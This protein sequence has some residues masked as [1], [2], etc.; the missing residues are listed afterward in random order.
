MEQHQ[1]KC[2]REMVLVMLIS[3]GFVI[4][5][6]WHI[7]DPRLQ[8]LAM[9][10]LSTA[11]FLIAS[12]KV[13]RIANEQLKKTNETMAD[14]K[15]E[16]REN[17]DEMQDAVH[18]AECASAAKS[19]FLNHMSHDIRT[20]MNAIIGY[21]SLLEE[22]YQDAER[23]Q[24]YANKIT[25]SSKILLGLID[26][27]LD[28]SR[29]ESGNVKLSYGTFRMSDV[30]ESITAVIKPQSDSKCQTLNMTVKNEINKD[31]FIGDK[32]RVCQVLLNLL[33][34]AVKYTQEGGR[35]D[36]VTTIMDGGNF[37]N[38]EFIVQDNGCGM[39][40]TFQ[41]HIF[42]PFEREDNPEI[43]NVQGTG[44][45]MSIAKNF[46]ELMD[47]T[48]QVK[49]KKHQ[50]SVFKVHL[51]LEIASE[52]E[53]EADLQLCF[54]EGPLQ[55]L[56][57][58]AAEDNELNGE[59]LTEMLAAK[60]ATCQIVSNGKIAVETFEA[61]GV[62]EYDLILMDVQM[63]VMNGYDAATAIRKCSH[64]KAKEIAII[65]MTADAFE[66][67]VQH[68][69]EAGMNAHIAKPIDME[70]FTNSVRRLRSIS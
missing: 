27:V 54:L 52:E 3:Y 40:E 60:G 58:L 22:Q 45:G 8:L 18:K 6:L 4:G 43:R 35:I 32:Q 59:I 11:M 53:K 69:F 25:L 44:L 13:V 39:S 57:F 1:V 21:S 15:Q 34:N 24:D 70:A 7:V 33:S 5:L 62:N 30:M 2:L 17:M 10:A 48:I 68:A 51:S 65:A 64:P 28:M 19:Q 31:Y 56:H 36:F 16:L 55:G 63:P 66:E 42:E 12:K 23:V 47:G 61:S 20:P 14:H 37:A 41:S 26:N 50:G 38:I 67:D 29:I 9:G 49:S 46:V